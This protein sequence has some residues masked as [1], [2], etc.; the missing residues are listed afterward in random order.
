MPRDRTALGRALAGRRRA[1][2]G[3]DR[4]L[5]GFALLVIGG[6]VVFHTVVFPFVLA[7]IVAYLLHPFVTFLAHY[8]VPRWGGTVLAYVILLGG[9]T[10]FVLHVIPKLEY[11]A[12]KLYIKFDAL[13]DDVP[14]VVN[15]LEGSVDTLMSVL[16]GKEDDAKAVSPWG[17]DPRLTRNRSL[18]EL[19]MPRLPGDRVLAEGTPVVRRQSG[20]EIDVIQVAK[21]HYR[22]RLRDGGLRILREEDGFVLR[23]EDVTDRASIQGLSGFKERLVRSLQDGMVYLSEELVTHVVAGA[24]GVLKGV[25]GVI[26]GLFIVLMA[27]AYTLIDI[28]GVFTFLLSRFPERRR[29][30]ARELLAL[31][32]QGMRGVVRGQVFICVVNGLLSLIGFSF[33]IPD[34]ALILGLVAGV[35][36]FIPIFGTIISS[37]PAVLIGLTVS[38]QTG[39]MVLGWILII[40]FIEAYILNP[41]IIGHEAHI[42]P[43]IVVIAV[44]SGERVFGIP[45]AFLAVPVTA[46]LK[47]VITFVYR[48]VSPGA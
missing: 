38:F 4:F 26:F 48:R 40:H 8:H 25:L 29:E 7:M 19:Q 31:L 42:H 20:G 16:P 21:G 10:G 14:G 32:D 3:F 12:N 22:I 46:A 9:I 2:D 23:P 24:Q 17:V 34:Y 43:V 41:K 1:S 28:P 27:A 6:L 44:V 11:E 35:L 45:G 15:S 33:L 36:S 39:L 30:A 5:V 13:L 47:A 37:V 18:G